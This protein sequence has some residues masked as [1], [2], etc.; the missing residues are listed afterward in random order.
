MEALTRAAATALVATQGG[1]ISTNIRQAGGEVVWLT[2]ASK[3]PLTILAN[4][5]RLAHLIES[6]QVD[7]I[8][9]RSRAPAWSALLAARRPGRPFGRISAPEPKHRLYELLGTNLAEVFAPSC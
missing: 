2:V 1:R 3:R 4:E 5:S 7:L 6:R 9:A 8:H